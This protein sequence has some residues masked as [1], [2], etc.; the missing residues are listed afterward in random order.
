MLNWVIQQAKQNNTIWLL[1]PAR[2]DTKAFRR[3]IDECGA[4]LQLVFITGR[5]KFNDSK[6]SAP[7]PSVFVIISPEI[8]TGQLF[9]IMTEEELIQDL[10]NY[11]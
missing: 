11:L 6:E 5:L 4:H 8:K 9:T 1:I 2:T 7:F 3:L 10:T